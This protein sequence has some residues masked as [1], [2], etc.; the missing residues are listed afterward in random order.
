MNSERVALTRRLQD[1]D[2]WAPLFRT[3]S[4]LY[5]CALSARVRTDPRCLFRPGGA[6]QHL[7]GRLR[8]RLL[9]RVGV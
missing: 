5:V 9:Q 4:I 2:Q 6:A 1:D 7:S 3:P 8:K